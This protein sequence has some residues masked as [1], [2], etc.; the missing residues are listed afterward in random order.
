MDANQQAGQ[1]HQTQ[2]KFKCAAHFIKEWAPICVEE[3]K[4]KEGLEFDNLDECERFY[5][6]YAHHAGFIVR[7][8]SRK[9]KI[10]KVL[11]SL[12]ILFAQSMD[13]N[14]LQSRSILTEMLS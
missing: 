14:A 4:P 5:K 13:L 9:K 3:L 1:Q 7:K 6:T 8:S 11:R 10:K 12:S 2:E